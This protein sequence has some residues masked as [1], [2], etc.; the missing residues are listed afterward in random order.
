[1]SVRYEIKVPRQFDLNIHSTN[2]SIHAEECGGRLRFETTNGNIKA[3]EIRGLSRCRT[4]NGSVSM[5]FAEI[6]GN[7][8]MTFSSKIPSYFNSLMKGISY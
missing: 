5:G 1:M 3:E 4:T 6:F 2:G 7:E 8:E